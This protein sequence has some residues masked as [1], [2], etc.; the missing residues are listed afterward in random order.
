[1]DLTGMMPGPDGV[2][3]VPLNP[4]PLGTGDVL[5][6]GIQGPET[7]ENIKDPANQQM[8]GA[9]QG[10]ESELRN[11]LVTEAYGTKIPQRRTVDKE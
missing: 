9:E 6:D 2:S 4:T 1:M 3:A 8:M 7:P 10:V 5:G 11:K